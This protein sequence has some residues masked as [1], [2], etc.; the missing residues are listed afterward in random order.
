MRQSHKLVKA[1]LAECCS[2][3]KDH[4]IRYEFQAFA[5]DLSNDHVLKIFE[6]LVQLLKVSSFE[7]LV[8]SL[9]VSSKN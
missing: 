3:I 1:R 8:Q 4:N 7:V 9:K 5:V 6:V 2:V